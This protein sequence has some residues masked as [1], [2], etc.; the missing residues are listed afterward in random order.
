MTGAQQVFHR[1]CR[2]LSVVGRDAREVFKGQHR[3]VVRNDDGGDGDA[4]KILLKVGVRRAEEHQ[5]HRLALRAEL[6]GALDLIR[7]LV[8]EIDDQRMLRRGK[9]RLKLLDERGEH[10]IHRAL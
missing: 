3:G 10:P 1:A 5:S 7:V 4:R 9:Q 8:D 2:A 6:H